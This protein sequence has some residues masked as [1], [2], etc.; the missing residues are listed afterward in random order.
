MRDLHLRRHPL[1]DALPVPPGRLDPRHLV[2]GVEE[3][4]LQVAAQRQPRLRCQAHVWPDPGS[5]EGG[6]GRRPQR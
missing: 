2:H 5:P 6:R 1:R 3:G 4:A